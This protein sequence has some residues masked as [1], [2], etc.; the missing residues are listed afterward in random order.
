VITQATQADLERAIG[1]PIALK[2]AR[3][4]SMRLYVRDGAVMVSLPAGVRETDALQ[5]VRNH[6][7]WLRKHLDKHDAGAEHGDLAFQ[8]QLSDDDRVPIFGRNRQILRS[9]G[10]P[11][12]VENESSLTLL[13]KP[14]AHQLQN[15]RKQLLNALAAIH[16]QALG[17]DVRQMSEIL[18]VSARRVS[19]KPMRTLWGSL[20]PNNSMSVNF[21]LIFAPRECTRYIA[22]HELAHVLERNHS[23]RFWAHVKRAFPEYQKVHAYLRK[24]HSF[25]MRLQDSVFAAT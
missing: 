25:L 2:A 1:R 3:G 19:I 11:P 23:A 7:P 12:F 10:G 13:V 8:L 9:T 24:Q 14:D 16:Q 5:F 18:G 17:N 4:R 6:I 21:A 22:A 20:G 15:T